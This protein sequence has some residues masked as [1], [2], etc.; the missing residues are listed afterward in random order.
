MLRGSCHQRPSSAFADEDMFMRF[1]R[2]STECSIIISSQG[3][4]AVGAAEKSVLVF[5]FRCAGT[6]LI[7][8]QGNSILPYIECA[9]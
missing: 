1:T 9:L 3:Q 7:D 6:N 8:I 2:G 5:V 4:Q